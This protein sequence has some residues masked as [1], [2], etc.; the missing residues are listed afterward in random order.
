MGIRLSI[1][2]FGSS[3]FFTSNTF[4]EQLLPF[5][6]TAFSLANKDL[7]SADLAKFNY[8]QGLFHHQWQTRSHADGTQS[9][10]GP[11]FSA[12]ACAA[13]HVRDGRGKVPEPGH[14]STSY[15]IAAGRPSTFHGTTSDPIYGDQIQ[16]QSAGAPHE[17]EVVVR[18]EETTEQLADG[19][20]VNL[21]A[22]IFTLSNPQYGPLGKHTK[23]S[24]RLPQQLVGL[25]F[26]ENTPVDELAENADPDDLNSD[27]ISGRL[28]YLADGTV[29]RFGWKATAPTILD[30]TA[31]AASTDM[32]ISTP[33][34]PAYAGDCTSEQIK[35][36]DASLKQPANKKT[37]LDINEARMLAHYSANLHVPVQRNVQEPDVIAG[38]DLFAALNCSGCHVPNIAGAQTS[39][40]A[41][42]DLLLH[43]MGEGLADLRFGDQILGREWRTPPLW[44]LGYTK[45]VNGN[46]NYLHDGRARNLI[47]A[48]MWHDGEANKSRELFRSLSTNERQQ[49]LSFLNSL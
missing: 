23:L 1:L 20:T 34:F 14:Y 39:T 24:G 2:V 21:R 3:L 37:E 40:K 8:G 42:T 45:E 31:N 5:G 47:E 49:L 22:P 32:G 46:Q 18:F 13:C 36:L 27:G 19:T 11:L 30:Q 15:V 29:G 16:Q 10:L 41:F 26:L 7:N 9:G 4:G 33:L 17:G 43:D 28:N 35:C 6:P 48:I 44:G 12:N 38:E 25:G